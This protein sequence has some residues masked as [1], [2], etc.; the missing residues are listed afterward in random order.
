MTTP[1]P[2]TRLLLGLLAL[3]ASFALALQLLPASDGAGEQPSDEPAEAG[4]P[5]GPV[6]PGPDRLMPSFD[7]ADVQ[8]DHVAA[9][10]VAVAHGLRQPTDIAF[11]PGMADAMVVLEKTGRAVWIER[12][13]GAQHT[14]C[15]LPVRSQS[16]LGL[17]GIAFAPDF[18]QSGLFVLNATPKDGAMRTEVSLWR[19]DSQR[20]AAPA[21]KVTSLLEVPQPYPN[22]NGGQVAFGPDGMLY[23]ALGDGGAGNDPLGNG[24][25]PDTALGKILRL[26]LALD[27]P[28]GPE[29]WAPDDNPFAGA[30]AKADI[31][32]RIF[33]LGARNPWRFAF[34][35]KGRLIV[36]DVGQD[37]W[38]EVD[39]V[40][41]GANL[42]WG[43][44]EGRVATGT[45][46]DVADDAAR[47]KVAGPGIDVGPVWVYGHDEGVSITGG[48]VAT[49]AALPA[50]AGRFVVGDFVRGKI[51]A[52]QLPDAPSQ[53]APQPLALG[54]F[55]I[56]IS[57]FGVDAKGDI[58]V[59]DFATG[60]IYALVA[61]DAAN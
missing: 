54:Q 34:D 21:T 10:L 20:P 2:R 43:R 59:A 37:H 9:A 50:I 41:P 25:K 45:P 23:V 26:Q 1:T 58:Y 47:C 13:T 55:A 31:D 40:P 11:P 29:L 15:E 27:M 46:D 28:D 24:Q 35:P 6:E 22:H 52:L 7:G 42:G 18:G 44:C 4:P 39:I 53:R 3:V 38:E 57:T 51:W 49:G 32:P 30:N 48:R 12:K 56:A 60:S 19:W 14:L 17:L 33:A 8:R 36:A 61:A 16:E 5:P